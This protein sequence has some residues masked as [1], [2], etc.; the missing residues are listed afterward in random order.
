MKKYLMTGMAALAICAAFTSCSKDTDV[1][2]PNQK[3]EDVKLTYDQAF[4]KVFGQPAAD[5]DWGFGSRSNTRTA[6]TN[7]NMWEDDGLTVPAAI[8]DREYEVVMNYFRTTPNPQSETVDIHNYF[9]QNVGY[10]DHTYPGEGVEL[11]DN[12]GHDVTITNPGRTQMDYI[13]VGPGAEATAWN[14]PTP[15]PFTWNE[16]DDHVNN[17]NANSGEIQ[18]IKYSGSEWFGFHDSYGAGYSTPGHGDNGKY[19][20]V[21]RNFVI[22]FIDVD[23]EVGC[24]VGFN[25]ESGKTSEGWRLE[26]DAYFDDRVI[27]LVPGE[28]FNIEEPDYTIRVIG[29]DLTFGED[30]DTDFDFNDVVFDVATNL[31]KTWIKIKAAGGTLPLIIGVENPDNAQSYDDYEIHHLLG[32][33]NTSVMINTNADLKGLNSGTAEDVEIELTKAYANAKDIPVYVKKDGAWVELKAE[34]GEP[35]SKLGVDTNFRWCNER[36]SLKGDY[37][38]FVQWVEKAGGER[39]KWY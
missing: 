39:V 28:G 18:Y 26:P 17:F 21:N 22:R 30:L 19:C 38:L 35:A 34:M 10:T 15:K 14:D 23:G 33:N 32:Y 2:N 13:F 3:A 24:Y 36:S 6:Y 5:Q 27:K 4:V 7:S 20:A 11:K 25:Y 16:G 8:T 29:E 31:P 9:I 37:P 1:Y 12:N